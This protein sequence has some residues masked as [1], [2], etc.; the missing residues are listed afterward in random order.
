MR[1]YELTENYTNLLELLGDPTIDN[2]V[3]QKAISEMEGSI[4][5]KAEGYAKVR[6][7][8]LAEAAACKAEEE[9]IS[10]MRKTRENRASYLL[11]AMANAMR[12]MNKPEI[13]TPI[14]VWKFGKNP[15]AVH[16]TNEAAILDKYW[17]H[18]A[19]VL[20]KEA[21][22]RDIKAELNVPGAELRQGE[23]LR[24]K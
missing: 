5:E 6:Q 12:S 16:I 20:D 1:L 22:K 9:R 11:E 14:G 18:P 15:P 13:T 4:E 17:K 19:P 23:S 24:F 10:N 2:E 8:L 21:I 7:T 3:V